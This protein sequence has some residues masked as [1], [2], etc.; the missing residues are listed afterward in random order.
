MY[1]LYTCTCLFL[2]TDHH[3]EMLNLTSR[4]AVRKTCKTKQN[5]PDWEVDWNDSRPQRPRSSLHGT[6]LLPDEIDF[7]V[8][9]KH[10]V[11]Y[12]MEFLLANF[13]AL[14]DL[15]QHVPARH[16]PHPVQKATVA[17]MK[18]L[19]KDE[20]YK[21]ETID[22]LTQLMKDALLTGQPQVRICI[23]QVHV[24]DCV[25]VKT[26]GVVR[27]TIFYSQIHDFL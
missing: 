19:F 5:L 8:F 12:I 11:Q 20:K 13:A 23:I 1:M 18:I 16:S 26:H 22:I 2:Y 24:Y 17:P 27:T 3:S 25:H 15:K 9:N 6:E 21:V 7:A 4:M 14:T 10:A